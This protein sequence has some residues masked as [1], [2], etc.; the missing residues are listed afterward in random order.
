MTA[1]DSMYARTSDVLTA[2]PASSNDRG[3]AYFRQ[4]G[5]VS[6]LGPSASQ[7]QPAR[8]ASESGSANAS[9]GNVS[10]KPRSKRFFVRNHSGSLRLTS[11]ASG[12][13]NARVTKQS[14]ATESLKSEVENL[15][16]EMQRLKEAQNARFSK[17]S[18]N[19]GNDEAP[20]SYFLDRA[21]EGV[22]S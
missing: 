6:D 21:S 4:R 15:K 12:G 20:P 5:S 9:G 14:Q 22:R 18:R 2:L 17:A 8:T 7:V 1:S 10:E 16:R 19:D 13:S 3:S 11:S